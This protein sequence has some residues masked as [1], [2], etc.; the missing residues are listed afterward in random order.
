MN[1]RETH[2]LPA[3]LGSLRRRFRAVAK[4]AE[5]PCANPRIAVGGSSE[6]GQ[7]LRPFPHGSSIAG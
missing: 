4:N 1:A 5:G 2:D 6:D 3:R 7:D